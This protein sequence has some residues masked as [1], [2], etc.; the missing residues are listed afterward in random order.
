MS[1]L[2]QLTK[3]LFLVITLLISIGCST[4]EEKELKQVRKNSE[5]IIKNGMGNPK[6]YEFISLVK[7]SRVIT[8]GDNIDQRIESFTSSVEWEKSRISSEIFENEYDKLLFPNIDVTPIDSS[9][10]KKSIKR[11]ELIEEWS[12]SVD[13]NEIGCYTYTIS[14]RG[15][16]SLGG[17]VVTKGT[18]Y[19][20]PDFSVVHIDIGGSNP[21]YTC[22]EK[23]EYFN[24]VTST[25]NN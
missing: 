13:R 16:N 24:I 23:E 2:N 7:E 14:F 3:S 12:K 15:E 11:L 10:L 22:G 20:K 25:Q 18:V 1:S 21:L 6:S 4:P 17:M 9:E 5:E 8:Q 19:T